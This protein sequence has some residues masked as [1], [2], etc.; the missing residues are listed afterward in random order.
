MKWLSYH[1]SDDDEMP[2][3]QPANS[4]QASPQQFTLTPP[5]KGGPKKST[6]GFASKANH[7][8]YNSEKDKQVLLDALGAIRSEMPDDES[9]IELYANDCAVLEKICVKNFKTKAENYGNLVNLIKHFRSNADFSELLDFYV[10]P[11]ET[12]LVARKKRLERFQKQRKLEQKPV[13]SIIE[14]RETRRAKREIEE[15]EKMAAQVE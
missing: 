13:E 9:K 14:G 12:M 6:T 3:Q 8:V 2:Q 11:T 4:S 5:K 1:L 7:I 10:H 15:L